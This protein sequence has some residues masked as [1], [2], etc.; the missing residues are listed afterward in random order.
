VGGLPGYALGLLA[1]EGVNAANN[2][3]TRKVGQKASN[4]LLAAEAIEAYQRD[5]AKR[6]LLRNGMPSYLLPYITD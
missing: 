2:S 1:T 4:S 6:G 3:I 5:Q